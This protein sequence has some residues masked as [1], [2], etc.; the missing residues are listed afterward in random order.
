MIEQAGTGASAAGPMLR[1]I[2]EG[3]LGANGSAPATAGA[4]PLTSLP[5][6]KPSQTVL[7]PQASPSPS[8]RP[9]A[10]PSATPDVLPTRS[11]STTPGKRR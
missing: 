3:L 6:V 9:T 8:R 4:A 10:G 5:K 7:S 11:G 1:Q 2:W